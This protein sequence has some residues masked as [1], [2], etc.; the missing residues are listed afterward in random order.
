M[1]KS[2]N[3]ISSLENPPIENGICKLVKNKVI[4]QNSET[5]EGDQLET[6][7]KTM[8]Q[9]WLIEKENV[10]EVQLI[11]LWNCHWYCDKDL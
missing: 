2:S 7:L 5:H 4:Q 6:F 8:Y 1:K 11:N 9:K 3:S 10:N